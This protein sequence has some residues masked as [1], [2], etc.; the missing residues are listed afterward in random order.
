MIFFFSINGKFIHPAPVMNCKDKESD[1]PQKIV[2]YQ[3]KYPHSAIILM[4]RMFKFTL[5]ASFAVT[6]PINLLAIHKSFLSL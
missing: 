6:A 2:W 5:E 4:L 1:K 3:H